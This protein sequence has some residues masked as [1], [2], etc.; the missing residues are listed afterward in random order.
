MSKEFWVCPSI[1]SARLGYLAEDI[2]AV[3]DAG[4]DRVHVDV[5]D[6]HYVPNLTFGPMICRAIRDA[7]IEA[8]L[9]VHLMVEPVDE[10]IQ[11]SVDAG[12]NCIV[13]HPEASR[14][15]HRSLSLIK[16]AGLEAGLAFN[17]TTSLDCLRI[18]KG[19]VDRVLIMSVN[20]GFAAQAFIPEVLPKAGL[21]R[22]ILGQDNPAL[23]IEIDGGVNAGNIAQIK[24]AGFDT[25][26]AGSYIYKSDDLADAISQL[27][28]T[29]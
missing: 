4:A 29:S 19:L 9:D 16:N 11:A 22:D 26:V 24:R 27:K 23:R 17:P 14:H 28:K 2:Q 8:P 6:N 25:V 15:V 5:M 20:P 1:L 18:L 21:A 3:L 10:M 12:A 13:F 7:G